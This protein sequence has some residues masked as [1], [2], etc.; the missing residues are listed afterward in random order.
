MPLS[1]VEQIEKNSEANKW[2][3]AEPR[4]HSKE[5]PKDTF[6]DPSSGHLLDFPGIWANNFFSL[7]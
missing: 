4:E 7:N 5:S 3:E 1:V 6:W 2:K